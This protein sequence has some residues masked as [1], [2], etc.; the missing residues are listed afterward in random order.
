MNFFGHAVVAGW[1][2]KRAGHLFGSMLPDFETMVRVPLIEVHNPDIRRGIDLHHRTDEAFHGTPTFLA[3]CAY[4]LGELTRSGVRRG[5]ARAVGHIGSEMF[6]DGCLAGTQDH[7]ETYLAA[8][9][10]EIDGHLRWQDDGRAFSRLHQRLLVWGA[11]HDYDDPQFVLA[12]I[13]DALRRRPALCVLDDQF[14]RVAEF[15]PS[16]RTMV[17]HEAPE[18][19]HELRDAL[20]SGD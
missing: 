13:G 1:S 7:V 20:G 6:L 14:D 16:L 15:L 11:P 5:T 18:L 8:L 4:A 3:L 12:R 17:E 10:L 9:H 2:D 19:L